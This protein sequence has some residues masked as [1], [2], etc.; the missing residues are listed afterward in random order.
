MYK[1][2]EGITNFNIYKEKWVER[3][4]YFSLVFMRLKA[5]MCSEKKY[6]EKVASF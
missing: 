6:S 5:S 1:S 2:V 3:V 4:A